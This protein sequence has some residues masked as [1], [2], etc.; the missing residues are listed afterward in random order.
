M[1]GSIQRFRTVSDQPFL[2]R[3]TVRRGVFFI[4]LEFAAFEREKMLLHIF[5]AE[6]GA[7]AKRR[8]ERPGKRKSRG[9]SKTGRGFKWQVPGQPTK[10]GG[11]TFKAPTGLLDL[12]TAAAGAPSL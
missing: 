9:R 10:G 1:L 7:L 3:G 11:E 4:F 12:R 2:N 8:G 6:S 5:R